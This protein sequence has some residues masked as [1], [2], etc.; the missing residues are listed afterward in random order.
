MFEEL[1][2]YLN[3]FIGAECLINNKVRKFTVN[4]V[5]YIINNLDKVALTYN[6]TLDI[7]EM[8]NI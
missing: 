5:N 7:L 3:S 4:D 8:E 6:R 1:R 2:G